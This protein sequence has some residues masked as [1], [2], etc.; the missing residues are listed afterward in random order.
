MM[1]AHTTLSNERVILD[2]AT[3]LLKDNGIK[4]RIIRHYLPIINKHIN[5]FLVEM[6]F[7]VTFSFDESFEEHIHTHH[8]DDY[9]YE[10]FSDGEKKRMDLAL[11]LTWRAVARLKNSAATNLLVLD[12]VFDSSL[13]IA[14]MEE[15]SKIIHNLEACNVFVMSHRVDTLIDKFTHVLQFEKVVDSPR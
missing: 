15:F 7:P 5:H 9:A 8:G 12:E 13:D 3:M 2:A 1:T 4:T 11:L 6:N 10:S 14:G